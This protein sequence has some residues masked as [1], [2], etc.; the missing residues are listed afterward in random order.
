[1]NLRF[2]LRMIFIY[3]EENRPASLPRPVALALNLENSIYHCF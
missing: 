3:P 2:F 1:V